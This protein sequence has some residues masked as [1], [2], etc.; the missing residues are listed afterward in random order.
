MLVRRVMRM[1]LIVGMRILL[2]GLISLVLI[3]RRLLI[4]CAVFVLVIGLVDAVGHETWC[5]LNW[6]C[7]VAR[8]LRVVISVSLW[9]LSVAACLS[10]EQMMLVAWLM[11]RLIEFALSSVVRNTV[12]ARLLDLANACLSSGAA[13]D[14]VFLLLIVITASALGLVFVM[15]IDAISMMFGLWVCS[16]L[17]VLTILGSAAVL[18][19]SR[20]PSLQ[21]PGARTLVSFMMR[22]WMNLGT[23]G[24]MHTL[25]LMLFTIGL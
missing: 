23:L 20:K 1:L 10:I 4:D 2:I 11:V 18:C 6:K 19:L 16:D 12:A 7:G 5:M 13:I 17:V 15:M 21:R 22:L 8:L 14:Y 9:C 24:S 25:C 3:L